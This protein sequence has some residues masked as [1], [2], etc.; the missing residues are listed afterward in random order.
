MILGIVVRALIL[1][2]RRV[3]SN[4]L[5]TSFLEPR[6]S[7][8]RSEPRQ[9]HRCHNC[10]S[11]VWNS[12]ARISFR[13]TLSHGHLCCDFIVTL[14]NIVICN[15]TQYAYFRQDFFVLDR[16]EG[17]S[18]LSVTKCF[19]LV[20]FCPV[21]IQCLIDVAYLLPQI[22]GRFRCNRFFLVNFF[23]F[24]CPLMHLFAKIP[25]LVL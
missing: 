16:I 21:S 6:S 14:P 20:V 25:Y 19:P 5:S 15:G 1:S 23:G 9:C 10:H 8:G 4:N 12:D 24:R 11:Q 18:T 17:R 22:D 13:R 2:V 3:K 7:V